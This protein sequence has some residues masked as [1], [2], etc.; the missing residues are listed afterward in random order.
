MA[1]I[2]SVGNSVESVT[3]TATASDAN[4]TVVVNP[5]DVSMD[6][7]EN[8]HHRHGYVGKHHRYHDVHHHGDPRGQAAT[9]T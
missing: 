6:V 7:G 8:D 9:P 3:V 2:A 5:G 4:A 1:Y